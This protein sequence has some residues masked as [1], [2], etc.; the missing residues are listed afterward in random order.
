MR[1]LVLRSKELVG[2][3]EDNKLVGNEEDKDIFHDQ[4]DKNPLRWCGH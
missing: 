3:K 1:L 4:E 2:S